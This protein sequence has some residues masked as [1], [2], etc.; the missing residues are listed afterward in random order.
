MNKHTFGGIMKILLFALTALTSLAT[1]ASPNIDLN[2]SYVTVNSNPATLIKTRNTPNNVALSVRVPT[3]IERCE[4]QDMRTRY[5]TVTSAS[6]CGTDRIRVNCGFGNGHYGN[7]GFN[8][9][10]RRGRNYNPPGGRRGSRAGGRGRLSIPAG[11]R[12]NPMNNNNSCTEEIARTCQ[13]TRRYCSNPYYVTVDKV[14]SFELSFDK[15]RKAATIEF[16][17]DQNQNLELDVVSESVSCIAKTIYGDN[18]VK[19]GAKIKLKRR[20]R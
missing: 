19:T 3:T 10:V 11:R 4:D 12:Y 15:F 8:T 20:C 1:I 9:P 6:E 14:K 16:S 2:S 13:V 5:V 17:L 18:G 7:G